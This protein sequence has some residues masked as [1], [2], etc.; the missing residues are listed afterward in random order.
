MAVKEH[1][2]LKDSRLSGAADSRF[3][4]QDDP[5]AATLGVAGNGH[6][7]SSAAPAAPAQSAQSG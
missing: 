4:P 6:A 2:E 1:K 3:S 5:A 7:D